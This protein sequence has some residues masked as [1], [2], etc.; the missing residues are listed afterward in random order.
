MESGVPNHIAVIMDGNGRWAAGRRLPR[1]AG[2]AAGFERF[3]EL[4]RNAAVLGVN[5]LTV[6]AFSAE[7]FSRGK[8][9]VSS[10]FSLAAKAITGYEDKLMEHN[11]KGVVI[12][13]LTNAGEKLKKSI[14]KTVER[15][16]KN[17]GMTLYIAFLYGG[18]Q[19][20]LKAA[21]KA[22][23]SGEKTLTE[24]I[25]KKY[26]YSP[27]CPDPDLIIR[28]GGEK[29]LSN[30]LLFQAAYSE[31]YFTDVLWPDFGK[32]D[33]DRAIQEFSRRKRNYGR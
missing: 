29:R 22:A 8:R 17:T 32:D 4:V 19:E 33:L 18:R 6:Y 20:I 13:D 9:E 5:H 30:F 15:L 21:E 26:L 7:N 25:F 11:I 14:E 2:H 24:D 31:L 27:D 1:A 16:S 23:A 28:S 3:V 10:L 12:G